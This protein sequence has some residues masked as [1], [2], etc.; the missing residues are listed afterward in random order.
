MFF[1]LSFIVLMFFVLTLTV[2]MFF[3]HNFL[4]FSLQCPLEYPFVCCPPPSPPFYPFPL[5]PP[6]PRHHLGYQRIFILFPMSG[7]AAS[8]FYSKLFFYICVNNVDQYSLPKY[9]LI[10]SVLLY[11][12]T[13]HI[14]V[15]LFSIGILPRK[16][17]LELAMAGQI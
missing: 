9:L 8:P 5:P 1:A 12:S 4:C 11:Y 16:A 3:V 7:P 17:I 6:L 14:R 2:I 15:F 13:V 10:G